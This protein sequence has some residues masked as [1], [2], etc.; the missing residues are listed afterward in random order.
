MARA[1]ARRGDVI[2][3]LTGAEAQLLAGLSDQLVPLF[4]ASSRGDGPP[5]RPGSDRVRERLFPRA[6]LDP[7]EEQAEEQWQSLVHPELVAEKSTA[8]A[9]MAANLSESGADGVAAHESLRLKLSVADAEAWIMALNDARVVA[10][11]TLEIS[12]SADP[13]GSNPPDPDAGDPDVGD[14]AEALWAIY[15]MLTQLQTALVDALSR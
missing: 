12:E 14:A 11:V 7:T 10:G 13:P 9:T 2:V 1:R 6:Y 8:L 3:D 4:E 15:D 5:A